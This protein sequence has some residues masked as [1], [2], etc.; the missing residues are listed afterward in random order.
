MSLI[1]DQVLKRSFT[2]LTIERGRVIVGRVVRAN[3]EDSGSIVGVTRGSGGELYEQSIRTSTAG[4]INGTCSCPVGWNCKHCV[5]VLL[6]VGRLPASADRVIPL[7]DSE[8]N[9]APPIALDG[10][11]L[12]QT[13]RQ[14]LRSVKDAVTP[15]PK[16]ETA[17]PTQTLLFLL[18]EKT[19]GYHAKSLY[20]NV[21]TVK[22]LKSGGYGVPKPYKIYQAFAGQFADFISADEAVLLTLLYRTCRR[23][24]Y[25]DSVFEIAGIDAD[26]VL[27]MLLDTKK[28]HWEEPSGVKLFQD[29]PRE[30]QF[31]WSTNPLGIQSLVVEPV[32]DA[33]VLR[34]VPARYVDSETG[35]MGLLDS[36]LTDESMAALLAAPDIK[37]E[38]A[39]TVRQALIRSFPSRPDLWPEAIRPPD[40]LEVK[41]VP[42]LVVDE[43]TGVDSA[44]L[45]RFEGPRRTFPT[46]RL[47]FEYA[48]KRIDFE[49]ERLKISSTVD[50]KL[51]LYV[52]D[53]HFEVEADRRLQQLGLVKVRQPGTFI[54][55][56][57]KHD[58]DLVAPLGRLMDT[59][60]N[61]REVT[62]DFLRDSAET[63]ESEGWR[64]EIGEGL[65]VLPD[66]A[67]FRIEVE[68][69]SI[70][71]FSMSLGF[72]IEGEL[73][74]LLPILVEAIRQLKWDGT[75]G[76]EGSPDASRTL[77]HRLKDG[78]YVRLPLERI[79][80]LVRTIYEW[81]GLESKLKGK[82][83]VDRSKVVDL[84][85]LEA[86]AQ[87]VT[88]QGSDRLR[89]L[90]R[91]LS[92]T[93]NIPPAAKPKKLKGDLR[94]YQQQGLA[95]LQL[96]REFGFG[97]ILADDMGLGK[98]IQTIAHILLEKEAGRL[99]RP[100]L[101]IAP[102]ST[103][104]NWHHE[105]QKFAPSLK[106][107]YSQGSERK[108][109]LG[110]LSKADVVLTTYPLLVRDKEALGETSYH[111]LVLDEAQYIKNARTNAWQA[112]KQIN[113]RHKICLT[114]TPMEN[115]LGEL[116]S[117]FEFLMPSFL[118][119]SEDFKRRYRTPIETHH[120]E[121]AR[122]RLARVVRPFML[123]RTKEA[124][125][126][127]LPPKTEVQERIE[128]QGPQRD[129]YESLRLAMSKRVRDEIA[130]KGLAR[131]QI[132]VLDA[133]LKL[134]QAC[135]D[136]RLVKS[137]AA[138]GVEGSAKLDR[139]IELVEELRAEGRQ[140]IV[141]SQFTTMLGLIGQRLNELGFEYVTIT[142]DTKDRATPVK[143]FQN[144]EVPLFLISLKAG[145]TGLNLTAAETVIHYDPWWNPAVERQATDRAHRIGQTKPV[146]VH[147][148]V[149]T[150]TVEERILELQSRKA[151][152]AGALLEG[153]EN[154]KVALAAEDIE[155]FFG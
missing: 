155:L 129:L 32:P 22:H 9:G 122:E 113:A 14:W 41:P 119:G 125:A 33:S 112:A 17:V 57:S 120:S 20:V 87:G 136:P 44:P 13:T 1:S 18:S 126:K 8:A 51:T 74:D 4:K 76:D 30:V 117:L 134:R 48:D 47:Y 152:L 12:D 43:H 154:R 36:G 64:I 86:A 2:R 69:S 54:R 140:A 97:A 79:A 131:S 15:K 3:L 151:D 138:K 143:R 61:R 106:V 98:T 133:L 5:A 145:G 26:R 135:C 137:D 72:E 63:L 96:L 45:S 149:A 150:D 107:V 11:A 35:A 65:Q 110:S 80:P 102:T 62:F 77:Y 108:K 24:G 139:L 92:E 121:V 66:E 58:N 144:R 84:A 103:L 19:P 147:K 124:V 114:G 46:F 116:W 148:L 109:V 146:F 39:E 29:E 52:R 115:H 73:V 40:T 101:I 28:S 99:D 55:F 50:D 83:M 42:I 94:P 104:P 38:N 128:L 100:A 78:R 90:G 67:E 27:G 10:P 6:R 95:W 111:L 142:G 132:V 118:G 7:F 60:M 71:W 53:T 81:Y 31:G 93:G 127:E 82:L 91:T 37:P 153:S 105:I 89:E 68:E 23:L 56:N 34:T 21:V 123:R 49:D 25:S 70:D 59:D 141:F 16:P 75:L 85:A 130:S 88:W